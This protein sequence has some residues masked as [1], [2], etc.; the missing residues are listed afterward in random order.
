VTGAGDDRRP[1]FYDDSQALES[2]AG[3]FRL[4]RARRTSS[5]HVPESTETPVPA[6]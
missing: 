2:V 6:A 3:V 5:P 1:S 4:A